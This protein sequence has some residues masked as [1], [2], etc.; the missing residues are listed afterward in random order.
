[1][2]GDEVVAAQIEP[3]AR[4]ESAASRLWQVCEDLTR[5]SYL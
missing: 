1:M 2:R 5:V 4:D 3:Q